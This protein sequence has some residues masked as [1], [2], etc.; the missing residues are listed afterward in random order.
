M[1][2]IY[3]AG[4]RSTGSITQGD[5]YGKDLSNA[6]ISTFGPEWINSGSCWYIVSTPGGNPV[7][8]GLLT[9][10]DDGSEL[11]CRITDEDTSVLSPGVWYLVIRVN[12]TSDGFTKQVLLE[13][14][15]V[16]QKA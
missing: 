4:T 8:Q 11:L 6:T 3:E 1:T 13:E 10:S 16:H 9:L 12:N 14:L 7:C 2:T 15:T 5:A